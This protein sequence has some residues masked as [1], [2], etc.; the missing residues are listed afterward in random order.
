MHQAE[1]ICENVVMINHGEK[2][3]DSSLPEIRSK[4][5]PRTILFEPLD[6]GA[7][8]ASLRGLPAV[9]DVSRAN[10]AYEVSLVGGVEPARV[11][12]EMLSAV[13]AVRVELNRPTLEDVF[14]RIVTGEGEAGDEDLARIRASLRDEATAGGVE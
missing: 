13:P 12:S 14:I 5:D 9:Q 10:G 3:L 2:V 4:Y 7:D 6:P 1:Q 11:M 8:V